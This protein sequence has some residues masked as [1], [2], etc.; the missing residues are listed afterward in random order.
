MAMLTPTL[1]ALSA[2]EG[3]GAR[4]QAAGPVPPRQARWKP[5]PVPAILALRNGGPARERSEALH[6]CLASFLET[7]A[8]VLGNHHRSRRSSSPRCTDAN[9]YDWR[10]T[11]S[12]PRL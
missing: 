9:G 8:R 11:T 3:V 2:S 12:R 6:A 7:Q 5:C 1:G 4:L 10:Q